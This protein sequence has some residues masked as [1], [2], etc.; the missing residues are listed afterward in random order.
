MACN[1][2]NCQSC[3]KYLLIINHQ[4][5]CSKCKEIKNFNEFNFVNP[6]KNKKLRSECKKCRKIQNRKMYLKRKEQKLIEMSKKRL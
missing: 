4:K 6:S 5:K 3:E 2:C 1:N